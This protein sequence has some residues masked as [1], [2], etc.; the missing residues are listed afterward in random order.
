MAKTKNGFTLIEVMVVISII[1]LLSS[2][3]LINV[4]E[5]RKKALNA[6]RIL[7]THQYRLALEN[8]ATDY[9]GYPDTGDVTD[10]YCI[11]VRPSNASCSNGVYQIN[12]A[13]NTALNPYFPG[14]PMIDSEVTTLSGSPFTL[15]SP[16]YGCYARSNGAC[17]SILFIVY[18]DHVPACPEG[19]TK[20]DNGDISYCEWYMD[21]S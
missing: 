15:G 10:M 19:G 21:H 1:A 4:S 18:L 6:K 20:F 9:G 17:Q 13:V 11:G 7:L 2:I 3:V 5:A 12:A 14:P 8:Y 16:M